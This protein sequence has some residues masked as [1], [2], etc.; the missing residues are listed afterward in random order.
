MRK[1]FAA[2]VAAGLLLASGPLLGQ[3]Q[4]LAPL[5]LDQLQTMAAVFG[6]INSDSVTKPDPV[7]L[8]VAAIRGMV[9]E[10]DPEAGEF[11][12]AKAFAE[13]K[14]GRPGELS[15]SGLEIVRRD[16]RFLL[17]PIAGGPAIAAGVQGDDVLYAVNGTRIANLG[18]Q[19]V[20]SLLAGPLG[21]NYSVTVFRESSL[22]VLTLTVE[23]RP[24]AG[25]KPRI[26]TVAPGIALLQVPQYRDD[27]LPETARALRV[28]WQQDPFRRGLILDLRGSQGGL[29]TGAVG[30][31]SM[32]LT[33]NAAVV[34]TQGRLPESN[35]Q[36]KAA[37]QFY[38]RTA[39]PDPLAG[40]PPELRSIPLVVLT[41][42]ATA[43][44][45]EIVAAALKDNRRATL[46]GQKTWGRGSI[47][48]VRPLNATEGVKVTTAFWVSPNGTRIHGQGVTPDVLVAEPNSEFALQQAIATLANGR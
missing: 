36:Y 12:D 26:A 20:E 1:T 44:G 21:S 46:V 14:S 24:P 29:L 45:A 5:P 28:A 17:Q 9:R 27:T 40:L 37:P 35:F 13:F 6:L 7:A 31:A 16:G 19:Q 3:R 38:L 47:Q 11:Y 30:M 15:N 4:P 25:G 33:E 41:D 10:A 18:T 8:V 34:S 22:S 43:A 42:G 48:T 2:C 32:F 39:G 23:R